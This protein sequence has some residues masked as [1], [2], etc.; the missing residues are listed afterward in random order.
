MYLITYPIIPYSL[1]LVNLL[2]GFWE[3]RKILPIMNNG[4]DNKNPI[5]LGVVKIFFRVIRNDFL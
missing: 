1:L 2:L 3:N 5:I 4:W